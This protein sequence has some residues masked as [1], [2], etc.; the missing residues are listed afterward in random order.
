MGQ[1][2]R[3]AAVLGIVAFANVPLVYYSVDLWAAEQ[4]LHPPRNVGLAPEMRYTLWICFAAHA[5]L[6][7]QLLLRR[8]DLAR[9][10]EAV[11]RLR[12]R[13]DELA[14]Y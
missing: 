4:Q 6:L 12:Q 7:V 5:L 2:P 10:E 14:D 11:E 13:R 8:L 3:L 9:V 1:A